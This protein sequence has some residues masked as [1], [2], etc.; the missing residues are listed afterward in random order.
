[1]S[2][3]TSYNRRP[4]PWTISEDG[5]TILAE[6]YKKDPKND[7]KYLTKYLIRDGVIIASGNLLEKMENIMKRN[8]VKLAMEKLS[9]TIKDYLTVNIP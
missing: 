9:P 2:F 3:T 1:M 6:K 7:R 5:R 4:D 8:L